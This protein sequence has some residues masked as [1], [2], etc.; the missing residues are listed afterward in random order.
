L[1]PMA[2][3]SQHLHIHEAAKLDVDADSIPS[4]MIL[5][6]RLFHDK[7]EQ[8]RIVDVEVVEPDEGE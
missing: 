7:L 8:S 1:Y 5:D 3:P 4:E 6:A 2:G